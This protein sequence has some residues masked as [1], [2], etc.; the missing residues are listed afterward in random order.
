MTL[1]LTNGSD[2]AG[3]TTGGQGMIYPEKNAYDIQVN[4]THGV[5][6]NIQGNFGITLDSTKSG[7]ITSKDSSKYLF[8]FVN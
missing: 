8:F 6:N 5:Y 3:L 2:N 4:N 7:I 1:G